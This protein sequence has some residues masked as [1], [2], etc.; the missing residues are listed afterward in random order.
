M[1]GLGRDRTILLST[2]IV[3]DLGAGCRD[4]ALL[5]GGR[6]LFQG[7]PSDL[8]RAAEGHVFE[9]TVDKGEADVIEAQHEI[10]SR[11]TSNGRITLR[12]VA[13]DGGLPT[14]AVAAAD[15]SLEEAYLAFMAT[16][17]RTAAARQQAE[18]QVPVATKGAH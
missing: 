12:G 4:L 3:A 16:R 9:A 2:H 18:G 15:P 5:D 6:V 10:V 14:G 13:P 1:S 8:I 7:S 17:G 11:T